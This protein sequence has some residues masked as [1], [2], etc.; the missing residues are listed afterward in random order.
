MLTL[1][2]CNPK[3]DN[4]QRLIVH[5]KLVR[6]QPRSDGPPGRTAG[7]AR[8]YAWIW[9]RLPFGLPGKLDRLGAARR[10]H[11]RALLWFWVFPAAE[12]LLPVRR[13]AGHRPAVPAPSDRTRRC[14]YWSST[15][16]TRSSTTWCSTSASSAWSATCGAT[17][18]SPWP[19]SAGC[20]PDGRPALARPGHA[21]PRRHHASTSSRAYAGTMPIFGVCLGHQAIGEAFGAV[22]DPGAGAAARQDV[23]RSPTTGAG[24]LRRPARPVHRHPVPLAGRGRVDAARTRS[25]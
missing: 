20:K 7:G 4:Y 5:A 16:T 14:A 25:R 10:R 11:G 13:R 19:R 1:T 18:R 21:R 12:P 24:V 3:W 6:S 9:R 8:M 2:T 23:R 15:T 22:V 17:T